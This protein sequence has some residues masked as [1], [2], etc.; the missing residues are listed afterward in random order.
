MA[1][2]Y[3]LSSQP[4]LPHPGWKVG[5]SDYAFDYAAHAFTFAVL[6]I[7]A[8]RALEP[9]RGRLPA[10]LVS[11]APLLSAAFSALYAVSDEVH[12]SFVPGR[13]AK[14]SDWLADVVG[15]VLLAGM[16]WWWESRS[17]RNRAL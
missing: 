13:W 1:W 6:A 11:P 15:I 14:F 17:G 2:I 10:L 5:L 4:K 3:W 16:L 7:L 8:W 12:Q 9:W